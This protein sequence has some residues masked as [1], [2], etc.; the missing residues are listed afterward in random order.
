MGAALFSHSVARPTNSTFLLR[1]QP[2]ETRALI[3]LVLLPLSL[4]LSIPN[5]ERLEVID[6]IVN[7]EWRMLLDDP[8]SWDHSHQAGQTTGEA[9]F[10]SITTWK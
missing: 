7:S 9:M 1:P 3:H 4:S 10:A 8:M 6:T 2:L 5:W